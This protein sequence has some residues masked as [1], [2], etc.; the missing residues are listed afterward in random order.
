MTGINRNTIMNLGIRVGQ[1]C[2]K[3]LDAKMQLV[4]KRLLEA[5]FE[6]GLLSCSYGYQPGVGAPC[7]SGPVKTGTALTRPRIGV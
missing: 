4:V 2:A 3:L 7:S 5:I 6:Q 1:G